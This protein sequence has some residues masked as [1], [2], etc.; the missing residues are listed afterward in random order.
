MLAIG[1]IGWIFC[2]IF[3]A[4]D[5]VAQFSSYLLNRIQVLAPLGMTGV[6]RLLCF[7]VGGVVESDTIDVEQLMLLL[8]S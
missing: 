2:F 8:L 6:L 4:V 5:T 3:V 1:E 7:N